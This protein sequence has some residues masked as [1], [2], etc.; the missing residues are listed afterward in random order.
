MADSGGEIELSGVGAGAHGTAFFGGGFHMD[1]QAM[2]TWYDVKLTTGRNAVLKDGAKALGL[3]LGVEVER[4]TD[5]GDGLTVTPGVGLAWSDVSL[6]FTDTIGS[7]GAR[8]SVEDARSLAGRAGLRAEAQMEDGLRLSG[9]VEATRE[10][11]EERTAK[12]SREALKTAEARKTGVRLG[13][14]GARS[15]EDGRYALRASAGYAARG[16]GNGEFDGGINFAMR[17]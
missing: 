13:I 16:S 4:R 10:F 5:M 1:A 8:V 15:W 6:D 11:A 2:A 7:G 12:I 17:F 3:A 14:G 9:S